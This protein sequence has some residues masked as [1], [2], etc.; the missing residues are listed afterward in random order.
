MRWILILVMVAALGGCV[1]SYQRKGFTG[2]YSETQ[3]SDDVY[4]ITFIGNGYTGRS[5]VRDFAMYR[6]AE[7]AMT[8]GYDYF[9]IMNAGD[10][11]NSRV[12][13]TGGA[14]TGQPLRVHSVSKPESTLTIRLLKEKGDSLRVLTTAEVLL[15][16]GRKYGLRKTGN[17]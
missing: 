14:Y 13:T 5:R 4:Q 15:H 1:T 6:A 17:K 8:S 16:I 10:Q 7:L 11:D 12:F 9:V 2:G 3:I